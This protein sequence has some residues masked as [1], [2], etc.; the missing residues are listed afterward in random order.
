[1]VVFIV[2]KTNVV[3]VVGALLCGHGQNK[4]GCEGKMERKVKSVDYHSVEMLHGSRK[5][6]T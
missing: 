2:L 4:D 1:M 6:G 3:F 5:P